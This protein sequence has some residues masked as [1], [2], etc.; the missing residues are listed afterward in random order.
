MWAQCE[1]ADLNAPGSSLPS[2]LSSLGCFVN[3]NAAMTPPHTGTLGNMGRNISR[4]SRLKELGPLRL[5]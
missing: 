3:G 4:D 5:R 1:A 2:N